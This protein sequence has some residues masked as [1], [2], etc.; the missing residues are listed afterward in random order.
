MKGLTHCMA[1]HKLSIKKFVFVLCCGSQNLKQAHRITGDS[2]ILV[3]WI[4]HCY[5]TSRPQ[6]LWESSVTD[7]VISLMCLSAPHPSRMKHL[8]P[9][10]WECTQWSTVNP[11]RNCLKW[12]EPTGPGTHPSS[13][14]VHI[15][16]LVDMR[17]ESPDPPSQLSR[18]LRSH[19]I[20]RI[21]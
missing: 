1:Q 10:Y 4:S 12:R 17:T 8:L 14:A 2:K 6:F 18:A 9:R 3:E 19:P 15:K 21:P 20:F 11:F 5:F 13:R 16:W 7:P